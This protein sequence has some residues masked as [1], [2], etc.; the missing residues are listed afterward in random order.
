M[1]KELIIFGTGKIADVIFYYATEECG[2]KVVAFTIDEKH[3][4]SDTYKDLPII[5]FHEVEKKYPPSK[6]NMFIAVGYHD[7][8]RIREARCSEAITKGYALVSIISPLTNL[9]KNVTTG[10]N[11]FIMPPSVIHPCVII[12]NNVFIWSGSIIGHHSTIKNNCWFTSGCNISGNVTIGNNC[13]FAINS[14]LGHSIEIGNE[15]FIGANTLVTKKVE[16]GKVIIKE[17]DKPI[18]L[19]SRQFLRFSNFS[20]L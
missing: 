18:K 7:M 20:S 6:Y 10:T 1:E 2:Y 14:T 17:S 8:N 4:T 15:V 5:P 11:C 9:P 19:N 16:S 12:G 3:K 13:F